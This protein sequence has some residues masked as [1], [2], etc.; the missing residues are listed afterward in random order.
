MSKD[1]K[2]NPMFKKL[3]TLA[4]TLM[5]Q[6]PNDIKAK[7]DA[8]CK[9]VAKTVTSEIEQAD[10]KVEDALKKVKAAEDRISNNGKKENKEEFFLLKDVSS[11]EGTWPS[12]FRASDDSKPL[13]CIRFKKHPDQPVACG[14]H[15]AG[16]KNL[17][18]GNVEICNGSIRHIKR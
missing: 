10:K 3:N 8:F 12:L 4:K 2:E 18:D 7:A 9:E 11:N 16:F 1:N 5:D 6:V 17:E 13:F 14:A 15:C